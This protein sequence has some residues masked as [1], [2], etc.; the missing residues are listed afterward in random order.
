MLR[1]TIRDVLWLTVV[2][3]L[4]V[5]LWLEHRSVVRECQSLEAE[6][7]R[8]EDQRREIQTKFAQ[9]KRSADAINDAVRRHKESVEANSP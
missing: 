3:G 8:L 4:A 2:V 9:L 6:R 7:A 1:F 5:V